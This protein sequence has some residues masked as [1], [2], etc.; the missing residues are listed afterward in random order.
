MASFPQ[1]GLSALILLAVLTSCSSPTAIP[2]Y[3]PGTAG[4]PA[5][6]EYQEPPT[7]T[8]QPTQEQ[9]NPTPE[10]TAPEGVA[11]SCPESTGTVQAYEIPWDDET[12]IGRVYTPPCYLESGLRYPTLYLLHGA[13]KSDQQWE[14]LGLVEVADD[15]ITRGEIPPLIIIMPREDTWVNLAENYFGDHLLQA[16][17]P[18]I[19]TEYR[20]LAERQYRALGGVSR[21]GNWAIR[22]GLLH[23]MTFRSLGAHSSPLFYLDLFRV[24]AWL[25]EIPPGNTPRIYQDISEGDPNLAEAES[26]RDILEEAGVSLE[27]HL[28]PGLHN[29]AYWTSHLEEYLLWYSAGWS[30]LINNS[31]NKD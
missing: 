31:H 10:E 24:P 26:L 3:K 28:Y 19:D 6:T 15:L 25:E 14:D 27:W 1:K 29:D 5:P 7:P 17:I 23:W 9:S 21:G 20:T 30:D 4:P 2:I 22:L 8:P 11:G 12:L 16:V 13:T 18:W